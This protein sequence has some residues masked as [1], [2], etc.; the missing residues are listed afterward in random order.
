M[1]TPKATKLSKPDPAPAPTPQLST[2][3][4]SKLRDGLKD[5]GVKRWELSPPPHPDDRAAIRAFAQ[6]LALRRERLQAQEVA[7]EVQPPSG[8]TPKVRKAAR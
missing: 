7:Q 3:R 2:Q 6:K 8:K 5:K 4:V 1:K